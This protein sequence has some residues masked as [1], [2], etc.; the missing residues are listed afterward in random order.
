MSRRS[1]SPNNHSIGSPSFQDVQRGPHFLDK[2]LL[3]KKII[4]RPEKVFLTTLP[5]QFG[6][7]VNMD[8]IWQFLEI[9]VTDLQTDISS[10]LFDGTDIS[11]KQEIVCNHFQR[12]PII[13][14]NL[15]GTLSSYVDDIWFLNCFKVNLHPYLQLS[16][17]YI[18]LPKIYKLYLCFLHNNIKIVRV[19]HIIHLLRVGLTIIFPNLGLL[20]SYNCCDRCST[21]YLLLILISQRALALLHT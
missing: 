6:K 3:I 5:P 4:E 7:S 21:D 10:T 15:A 1:R 12:Y 20:Y 8:M 16:I 11:G 18:L 9:K 2:T 13:Y 17:L 14:L 19:S